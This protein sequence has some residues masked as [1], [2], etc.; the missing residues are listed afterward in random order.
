[1]KVIKYDNCITRHNV[2]IETNILICFS[3]KVEQINMPPVPVSKCVIIPAMCF[4]II[5]VPFVLLAY[6]IAAPI[7]YICTLGKYSLKLNH[8][9][10]I[11]SIKN[12]KK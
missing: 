3:L 7:T 1:M 8:D 12:N 6:I 5:A 2:N 4:T 9:G 10:K 11:F